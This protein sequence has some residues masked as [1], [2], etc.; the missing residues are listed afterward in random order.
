MGFSKTGGL[1]LLARGGTVQFNDS[2]MPE[3][4]GK[5][6]SPESSTSWGLLDLTYRTPDELWVSG[7][8][9]NL[10]ASFDGGRTWQKDR[11]VENVPSNLYRVVFLKPNQGFVLG[12]RG[13]LLRYK[14]A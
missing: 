11:E 13:A 3:T 7:G 9:G 10:L 6:I 1:W 5:A 12:Q 8:S 14:A 2:N 4:W